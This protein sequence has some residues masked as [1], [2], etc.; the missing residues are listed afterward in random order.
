MTEEKVKKMVKNE[1][2]S[3]SPGAGPVRERMFIK[4]LRLGEVRAVNTRIVK[5]RS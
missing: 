3:S 2:T 4:L 1:N 5:T